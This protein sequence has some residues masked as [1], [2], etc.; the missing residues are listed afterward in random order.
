MSEANSYKEIMDSEIEKTAIKYESGSMWSK[1]KVIVLIV[2][3]LAAV[4]LIVGIALIAAAS[5]KSRNCAL[6]SSEISQ[7]GGGESSTSGGS[8]VSSNFCKFSQ[9]AQRIGLEEFLSKVKKSY[10]ALHA[11]AFVYNPEVKTPEQ[12]KDGFSAYDPSPST[13][14]NRTDTALRLLEEINGK[15]KELNENKLKPRERKAIAQVKLYLKHVFGQPYDVNYYAGDWMMGPN[16]FCWQP[17]CY[18]SNEIHNTFVY[19]RPYSLEEVETIKNHLENTKNGILRYIENMK[20]GIER[21]M[22]RSVEEC[23]AGLN[24]IRRRFQNISLYNETG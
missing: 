3:V 19:F 24:A 23:E 6:K 20:M 15:T 12:L 11:S 14:K 18:I 10:Y 8:D 2:F 21:G 16:H 9:E 7:S 17:V 1:Q 13:I 5:I 4:L 22:I